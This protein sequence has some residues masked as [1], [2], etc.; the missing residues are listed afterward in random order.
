MSD[1]IY[2]CNGTPTCILD[3]DCIRDEGGSVAAWI[4]GKNLYSLSGVHIGWFDNGIFYD[5]DNCALGFIRDS[6]GLPSRP[7]LAGTPGRPGFAGRPGKP[8]FAG[9]PGRPGKGGWSRR[10]IEDYIQE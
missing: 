3:Q 4:S 1:W 5:S 7:G 2:N 6:H 9:A 8:G 10:T